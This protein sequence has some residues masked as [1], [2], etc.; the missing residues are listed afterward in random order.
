MTTGSEQELRESTRFQQDPAPARST[1]AR[2]F[3]GHLIAGGFA[4]LAVFFG[5]FFV[6]SRAAPIES[7]V[8]APGVVSVDSSRK[9][10]QHLEGGIIQRILVAD[11]DR[12]RQ[13]QTLI[14]LSDVQPAARLKQLKA[15]LFEAQATLARLSAERDA[16]EKVSFPADLTANSDPA[17]QAAI[18][19]Q[20]SVF[21]SRQQ[22][23]ENRLSLLEQRIARSREEIGGLEGQIGAA[24]TQQRLLREELASVDALFKKGLVRKPR[25][26]SLQ[27]RLAEIDG[28]LASFK[29]MIART[30]QSIIAARLEMSELRAQAKTL[31]VDQ[32]R[33]EQ[34]AIYELE[35]KI[36]S[37]EDVL[38]RTDVT[39]P[40][41]G[42]VVDLQV[43][44]LDGVVSPGQRLL[45]VVP[46]SDELVIEASVD[47]ADIE[48]VRAGMAA[49]VQLTSL[50][51]RERLP[52]EGQVVFV[53]ADRLID[54]QSGAAF[55]QA[56]VQLDPSSVEER[57]T[58]LQAG[59]GAEVF[60]RTGQR[61]ALEYLIAPIARL[62]D[63]GLRES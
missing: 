43:H 58:A 28:E 25:V 6:W 7:A 53:S 32:L 1:G 61:T 18:A 19:G 16:A 50:S 15:Q 10:I 51:R 33:A 59:M 17:A 34:S 54:G 45:D 39:S 41:D 57:G 24:Q 27:R 56:R 11:G 40:I 22:L 52:I 49:H 31:V 60:I 62:L 5:I 12:V 46:S 48:E 63:R 38:R 44:T 36:V 23:L 35:Q 8:I 47:P 42:V 55:Y 37:A 29:A 14:E 3:P 26:L 13:G 20:R 2:P 21:D 4:I 9:S 30:E